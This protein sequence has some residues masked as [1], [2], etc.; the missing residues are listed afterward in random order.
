MKQKLV[1]CHVTKAYSFNFYL[2]S[3]NKWLHVNLFS[4][5]L[6]IALIEGQRLIDGETYA[7]ERRCINLKVQG[8]VIVFFLN[9]NV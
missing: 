3:F 4:K 7:K 6:N 8:L 2:N 5:I 1:Q 9:N